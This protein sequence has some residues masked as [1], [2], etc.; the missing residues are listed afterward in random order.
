MPTLETLIRAH[1]WLKDASLEVCAVGSRALLEA[2]RRNGL[3][4]PPEPVDLD[5]SWRLDPPRGIRFL[6]DHGLD[7]RSTEGALGRGT[8]G[9][10]LAG[11][12]VEITTYR[13]GG[14]SLAERIQSDAALRDMTIGALYWSLFDDAIHD[15]V[16]GLQDWERGR[17]RACG[18]AVDRIREHPVR[19]VRYLRRAVELG[20]WVEASTRRGIQRTAGEVAAAIVPEALAEELRKVLA[21]CESPGI[22]FQMCREEALLEPLL[23]EIAPMFD[24]RPAGRVRWHP[25]I[26]QALH[27][28]LALRAAAGLAAAAGLETPARVRL[29]LAVLCHDLGKGR[30]PHAELPSHAG[31]EIGGV[32]VIEDLFRRLPA[33]GSRRT[34]RLCRVGAKDH[35]LLPRLRRL[36]PG[37]LVDLWDEDLAPT[38]EDHGALARVVRCD[39]EG[40]LSPE[41]VGLP[42]PALAPPAPDF[43]ALERR[44]A[45]DLQQLDSILRA[46]SGQRSAELFPHDIQALRRHLREER[47]RAV[48]ASDFLRA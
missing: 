21:R 35:L 42:R 9:T 31:H 36:K 23:P 41:A 20:F 13:G 47:C 30:T 25:E 17:I 46:V 2:C 3:P 33:L 24:G 43:D 22:F 27:M 37:T 10:E 45:G 7:A 39:Q 1:P 5:L 34:Q 40:R 19:A 4:T 29:L 48:L 6:A 14:A 12:R 16:Q 11:A 38:R 26:S 44:V 8:L 18:L 15:P 28:V 32:S